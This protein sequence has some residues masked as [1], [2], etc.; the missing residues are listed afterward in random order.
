MSNPQKA[1][2]N[3]LRFGVHRIARSVENAGLRALVRAEKAAA[4]IGDTKQTRQSLGKSITLK[5]PIGL[6][7]GKT[8]IGVAQK[9]RPAKPHAHF[10][11][12]TKPRYRKSLGGKFRWI[13]RPT[14]AQLRTGTMPANPFVSRAASS[15][16]SAVQAAMTTAGQK[17]LTRETAKLTR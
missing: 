6:I 12:G 13:L 2:E 17:A 15:S 7:E 8:G 9:S 3:L 1:V 5:N 14:A 16:T 11:A 10:N 4:P